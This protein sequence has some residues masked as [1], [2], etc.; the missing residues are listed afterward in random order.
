[1][2]S[3]SARS[4]DVVEETVEWTTIGES[5]PGPSGPYPYADA[6]TSGDGVRE[7]PRHCFPQEAPADASRDEDCGNREVVW[8]TARFVCVVE[9]HHDETEEEP[10]HD[11]RERRG[12]SP[13]VGF[14]PALKGEAFASNFP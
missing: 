10:H 5:A 3:S 13:T 12:P 11:E 9:A 8:E 7:S 2:A 1:V 4:T 6:D 14:I